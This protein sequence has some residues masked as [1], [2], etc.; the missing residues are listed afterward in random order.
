MGRLLEWVLDK[1]NRDERDLGQGEI[2]FIINRQLIKY[3]ILGK[4]EGK[5]Q[6][7][8]ILLILSIINKNKM[9]Y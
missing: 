4:S 9:L 1:N 8:L 7:W 3:Y 5:V 2:N 6:N